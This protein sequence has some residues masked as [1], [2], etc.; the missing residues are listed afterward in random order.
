MER[1]MLEVGNERG[2]QGVPAG[3]CTPRENFS[4]RFW[5]IRSFQSSKNKMADFRRLEMPSFLCLQQ[6]RANS[7]Q[8]Q[9]RLEI[10]VLEDLIAR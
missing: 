6:L 9:R 1:V 2:R 7:N 5:H 4:Q 10:D 8:R 3:C